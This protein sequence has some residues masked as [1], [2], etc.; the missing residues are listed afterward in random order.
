MERFCQQ[1][2]RFH[3]VS[4]FEG[5]RR[6]CRTQLERHN[7]R[8]R[9][10]RALAA[11][12]STPASSSSTAA[13]VA[14]GANVAEEPPLQRQ[15]VAAPAPTAA[16][17]AG[18]AAATSAAQYGL[19][20]HM[21]QGMP[22]AAGAGGVPA[23]QILANP[24]TAAAAAATGGVAMDPGWPF[25]S[26]CIG[27]D[28]QWGVHGVA[29]DNMHVNVAN[30]FPADPTW[31]WGAPVVSSAPLVPSA[32]W[33]TPQ[34]VVMPAASHIRMQGDLLGAGEQE[35]FA[36]PAVMHEKNAW[37]GAPEDDFWRV[38]YD[39]THS[40]T[41]RSGVESAVSGAPDT[42]TRASKSHSTQQGGFT[43]T[44]GAID[45]TGTQHM[46]LP[47]SVQA[48]AGERS[49]ADVK[50][51]GGGGCCGSA[52][53]RTSQLPQD[54]AARR[55]Q[56][57]SPHEGIAWAAGEQSMHSDALSGGA[58]DG[59]HLQHY[60]AVGQASE[61]RPESNEEQ[62]RG[63]MQVES[64]RL[65]PVQEETEQDTEKLLHHIF[66]KPKVARALRRVLLG[67]PPVD[68][69][70]GGLGTLP[71]GGV[72]KGCA[73]ATGEGPER[74][75]QRAVIAAAMLQLQGADVPPGARASLRIC[76]KLWACTPDT[77]PAN[78]QDSV[79]S[80]VNVRFYLICHSCVYH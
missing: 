49:A 30:Q 74:A 58:Q 23:D 72:T 54:T 24:A 25:T 75:R 19:Q 62:P 27:G 60:A 16:A 48:A 51:E 28:P 38:M 17:K 41:P 35:A 63:K 43:G 31:P 21:P 68:Q 26:L 65:G 4:E 12:N 32:E 13:A 69:A 34:S 9:K 52:A 80:W 18:A 53:G 66:T 11:G 56:T 40:Q 77:L 67:T 70:Q 55:S 2:S 29:G 61:T 3:A 5:D 59:A 44:G 7:A 50:S 20:Y 6:S 46:P 14:A 33:E 78:L 76:A 79:L 8:R 10:Q 15:R 45:A 64:F 57:Q 42:G 37:A 22:G 39:F 47:G 71:A 73:A 36:E 1:C